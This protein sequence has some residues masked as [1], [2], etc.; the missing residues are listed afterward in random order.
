MLGAS[1]ESEASAGQLGAKLQPHVLTS[2]RLVSMC[3]GHKLDAVGLGDTQPLKGPKSQLPPYS[4]PT[5][6]PLLLSG[7]IPSL[8]GHRP[9]S[10]WGRGGHDRGG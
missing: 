7:T 4:I 8:S 1:L 9:Q 2:W 3:G 5:Q 10:S 6:S